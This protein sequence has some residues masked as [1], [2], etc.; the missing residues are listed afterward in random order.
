MGRLLRCGSPAS[1]EGRIRVSESNLAKMEQSVGVLFL[2]ADSLSIRDVA[3]IQAIRWRL[4]RVVLVSLP[5]LSSCGSTANG[6]LPRGPG[7][8]GTAGAE[9]CRD[10]ALGERLTRGLEAELRNLS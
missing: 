7:A 2:H 10:A 8:G 4:L 9:G 6:T 3:G 1:F 5:S